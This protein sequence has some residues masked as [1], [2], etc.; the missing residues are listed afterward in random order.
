[1]WD[2]RLA[3]RAAEI[4]VYSAVRALR[5]RQEPR[6]LAH[7]FSRGKKGRQT[8]SPSGASERA[9]PRPSRAVLFI[10]LVPRL[11]PWAKFRGS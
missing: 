4:E 2:I 7:G 5:L 11:K 1:M 3:M 8:E 9:F 10:A 6:N